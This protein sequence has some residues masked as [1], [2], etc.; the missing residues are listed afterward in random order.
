MYNSEK[1]TVAVFDF[2]GT[3][4]YKD[5]FLPFLKFI[6]PLSKFLTG[7]LCLTP[8]LL[9]LKL[10]FIS[11]QAAK[12][13]FLSYY[14]RDC[15]LEWFDKQ[16]RQ[17][18]DTVLH[19]MIRPQMMERIHWHYAQNHVCI[20]ISAS[21]EAYITYWAQKNHIQYVLATKLAVNQDNILTGKID[22]LNCK[23]K[24]KVARLHQWTGSRNIDYLY[25]YGDSEGDRDLLS[26]ANEKYYRGKKIQ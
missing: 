17:Y 13:A 18:A 6:M 7:I 2:D 22:G 1:L 4:T 10:G 23:G 3:I 5:T 16:C 14:I 26:I 21:P 8:I 25:V 9:K 15:N 20:V 12:D 19:K 11:S 24:E